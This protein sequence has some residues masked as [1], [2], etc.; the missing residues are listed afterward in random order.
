MYQ[1]RAMAMHSHIVS[2]VTVAL[3][4][5]RRRLEGERSIACIKSEQ[6]AHCPTSAIRPK[7]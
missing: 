3:C 2:D 5:G 4:A 7:N 1:I 6:L